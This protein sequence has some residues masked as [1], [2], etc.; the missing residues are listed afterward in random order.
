MHNG[1]TE[2][3]DVK[4]WDDTTT[5]TLRF[6]KE[7]ADQAIQQGNAR[8]NKGIQQVVGELA[9][10]SSPL[11]RKGNC[12]GNRVTEGRTQVYNTTAN[13]TSPSTIA[14]DQPSLPSG[15]HPLQ[16]QQRAHFRVLYPPV[17]SDPD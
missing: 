6:G 17:Y 10:H 13:S 7:T 9:A 8:V 2:A 5:R 3:T 14:G 4:V 12:G 16:Q 11:E 1:N 15:Y